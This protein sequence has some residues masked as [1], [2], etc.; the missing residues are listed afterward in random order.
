MR[1]LSLLLTL[2]WFAAGAAAACVA[3]EGDRVLAGDLV[4]ADAWFA[5]LDPGREIGLT[6]LAGVT[7][8]IQRRELAALARPA[9]SP[10]LPDSLAD[11]CVERATEMLTVRQLQ[12]VLDAATGGTPV[13]ILEYSRF[14]VPRGTIEF[15]RAGLTPAGLWRGR[16]VYGANHTLPI[17][18]VVRTA[19]ALARAARLREVERGERVKVEVTSGA[20]RLV[21][22][23]VAESAGGL[24]DSVLVRNPE[25][26][27]LFQ[28]KVLEDGKVAVHK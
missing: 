24:G 4:A 26:G 21:F 11:V 3:V 1:I 28:A 10:P 8:V 25:N 14:R 17:W 27:H 18:A 15:N 22:E 9:G 7:R 20:A 16:V 12:P 5:R 13:A 6:P 23:A 19:G 2:A